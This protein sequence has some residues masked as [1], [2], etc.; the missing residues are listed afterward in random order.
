MPSQ[1]WD[2][3]QV[4]EVLEVLEA[5]DAAGG[6]RGEATTYRRAPAAQELL[7]VLQVLQACRRVPAN[8]PSPV[9]QHPPPP[10]RFTGGVG[11]G[12]SLMLP[13]DRYPVAGNQAQQFP[14]KHLMES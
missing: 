14:A 12:S 4:L 10:P 2:Y 3:W 11:R 9:I 6:L 7:Q 13:I 1:S 5:L 8:T